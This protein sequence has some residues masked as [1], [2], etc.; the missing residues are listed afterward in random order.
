MLK[1]DLQFPPFR[2]P[3]EARA[4]PPRHALPP[5]RVS[6]RNDRRRVVHDHKADSLNSRRFDAQ[7]VVHGARLDGV[8][9][10]RGVRVR[11][12]VVAQDELSEVRRADLRDHLVELLPRPWGDR[13]E[14]EGAQG[15]VAA[16]ERHLPCCEN[17]RLGY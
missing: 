1:L 7:S 15:G 13:A 8:R 4:H 11:D 5:L 6:P 2:E 12:G 16:D 10:D 9:R 3:A 14:L 17:D